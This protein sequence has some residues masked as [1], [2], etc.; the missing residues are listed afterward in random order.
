MRK[1]L[2]S[3]LDPM[4]AQLAQTADKIREI[5]HTAEGL[6]A[7]QVRLL[8]RAAE[9]AKDAAALLVVVEVFARPARIGHEADAARTRAFPSDR[10]I[11]FRVSDRVAESYDRAN[12]AAQRSRIE[13]HGDLWAHKD[14]TPHSAQGPLGCMPCANHRREAVRS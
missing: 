6:T 2:Q 9:H 14:G 3:K 7:S 10:P 8:E 1:D 11:P 4:S 12:A 5:R 13:E